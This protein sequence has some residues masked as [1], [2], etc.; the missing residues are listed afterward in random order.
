M[1]QRRGSSSTGPGQSAAGGPSGGYLADARE[2]ASAA[3]RQLLEGIDPMEARRAA[4]ASR[5]AIPTFGKVAGAYIDA[6][7]TTWRNPKHITQWENTLASHAKLLTDLPVDRI[8]TP[9]IVAVLKPIWTKI[10]ET[11][12]RLRGRIETVLD[13]ETVNYAQLVSYICIS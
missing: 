9:E 7:R 8:D 12:G 3:R 6:H 2:A 13:A 4:Q 1:R 5:A 11:A 10:P